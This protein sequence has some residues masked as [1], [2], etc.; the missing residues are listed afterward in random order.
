[1]SLRTRLVAITVALVAAGLAAAGWAT[2]LA[3]QSFLRDRVDQQLQS[4]EESALRTVVF[5]H[6]DS[7]FLP[8]GIPP[9]AVAELRTS[10]GSVVGGFVAR[11]QDGTLNASLRPPEH[12]PSKGHF[13]AHLPGGGDYRFVVVPATSVRF[14]DEHGGGGPPG[15]PDD[16][17]DA[18]VKRRAVGTL[19]LGIP[20]KDVDDTLG[21]LIW[22]EVAVGLFTLG[23]VGGLSYWGVRLGLRPLTSI[24]QT[25]DAIA[26]GDLDRRVEDM[27]PRTEVGRLAGALNTMLARIQAAF[28][29]RRAAERRL[30]Q[31]VA[32]AS[33]E[34]QTPLTS[35]RGYAELFRRGAAERPDDLANAM[36][37]IESEAARMGILVDD[38]LLLARM[39]QGPEM[40]R[41]PVELSE[42][43]RELVED[44]RTVE[45]ERP[46]AFEAPE[47]VV[48]RGDEMRLRQV[49]ANLLSNARTHTPG[50]TAVTVRV[51]RSGDSALVEVEDRGPGVPAD[52]AERVFERFYRVDP[53]RTRAS[54]GNGLGLSIVAAIADAHGGS[55]EVADT[56]G[57]GATFRIRLPLI[58]SAGS[59]PP[60]PGPDAEAAP[61]PVA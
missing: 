58:G 56:A 1:V 38:M 31:F 33:H 61:D 36:R 23:A 24:E 13:D 51:L 11:N 3:L 16:P 22:I 40:A 37:R 14:G 27:N 35:V 55:A 44:A 30:R 39:D 43:T 60:A 26:A 46:I 9:G 42:L 47:P 50:D 6:A 7:R 59:P 10:S 57:G 32:D 15:G 53:S 41:E 54:G 25:A 21:R 29:E 20:L 19:L 4:S 18:A 8:P 12:A 17:T 34:L 49:V 48:V 45:P 2:Y 28:E 52:V 5:P